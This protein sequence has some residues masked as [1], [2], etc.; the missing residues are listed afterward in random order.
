M[1]LEIKFLPDEEIV[2]VAARYNIPWDEQMRKLQP[3]I[4]ARGWL[5][6][7][8]MEAVAV[9]LRISPGKQK[10][11]DNPP[12]AI[13]GAT[14]IALST[15]DESRKW[16]VLMDLPGVGKSI[17]PSVLHWFDDGNYPIA[18][19]PALWSCSAEA[20]DLHL[21]SSWL[22]YTKFCRATAEE[23]NVTMRTLDRALQRHYEEKRGK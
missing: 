8:N 13:E 16:H 9:W 7:Q 22:E 6:Q 12:G 18:T 1:E 3:D 5:S 10:F 17:A 21:S 11:A 15:C 19:R 20:E 23:H 4:R 2:A 14:A